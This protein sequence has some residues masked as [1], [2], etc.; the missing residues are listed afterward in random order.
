MCRSAA[1]GGKGSGGWERAGRSVVMG[2]LCCGS[3]CCPDGQSFDFCD[4]DDGVDGG[5][6][7]LEW[8]EGEG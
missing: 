2:K 8:G 6:K 4:L 5:E 1:G 3:C 7:G